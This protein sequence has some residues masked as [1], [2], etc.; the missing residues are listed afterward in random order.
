VWDGDRNVSKLCGYKG[1]ENE[2]VANA[3]RVHRVCAEH[4]ARAKERGMTLAQIIADNRAEAIDHAGGYFKQ[5]RHL[6]WRAAAGHED[7]GPPELPAIHGVERQP[8]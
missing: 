8:A 3:P 2:A 7:D 5:W 4:L 6:V 1:C